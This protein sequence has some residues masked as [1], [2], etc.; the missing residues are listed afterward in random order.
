MRR[1]PP[2]RLSRK[3][4]SKSLRPFITIFCE[5]KNTEP[6]YM[7]SF[8]RECGVR[9]DVKG[10]MGA[11][12]TL[13][14][15]ASELRKKNRKK[16]RGEF[17][18]D[19]PIW[20]VFDRDEHPNIDKARDKAGANDIKIAFSNPCIEIWGILHFRDHDQPIHRHDLQR[21]LVDFMPA[22]AKS[23]RFEYEKMRS[24]YDAA[25]LRAARMERRRIEQGDVEGNPFTGVYLLMRAIKEGG[26]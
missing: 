21:S 26:R 9:V 18:K 1:K 7:L 19:D 22:Y 17:G 5:G 24:Q 20:V 15:A 6:D 4:A 16:A 3:Q 11:P 25:D 14:D 10:A 8:A 2:A 13:V 12:M 23:K